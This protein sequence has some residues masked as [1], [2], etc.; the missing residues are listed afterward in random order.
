MITEE[1]IEHW[2]QAAW[3]AQEAKEILPLPFTVL[4]AE[5]LDALRFAQRYWD[6]SEDRESA[7]QRRGLSSAVRDGRFSATIRC[8]LSELYDAL[9][10]AQTRY[11]LLS[12]KSRVAPVERAHFA[13]DEL[14]AALEW[15]FGD[16]QPS[17][18]GMVL[19]ALAETHAGARSHD[20]VA[21][22]LFDYAELAERNKGS[23]DGLGGFDVALI[24]QAREL[25]QRLREQSAGPSCLS[26]SPRVRAAL[27]LRNRLGSMVHDR[28]LLIRAAARFVFRGQADILKQVSSAYSRKRRAENR[29][30]RAQSSKGERSVP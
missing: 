28:I 30:R 25:A 15:Y 24:D 27:L 29:K 9:Q 17:D 20:A 4:A 3:H 1:R 11:H 2:N 23:L 18:E 6:P 7:E 19:K 22:A 16:A 8:D 21:S 14:K 26:S 12:K 5:A 13:W 10:Q